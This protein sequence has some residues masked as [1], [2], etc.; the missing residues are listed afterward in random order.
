MSQHVTAADLVRL[1]AAKRL[2]LIE[3]LWDSLDAEAIPL[4]DWQ[5]EELDRRLD[6]LDSGASSGAPWS[7]VRNRIAGKP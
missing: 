2:E 3:A 7:E 4:A 5:R 6:A 1:P